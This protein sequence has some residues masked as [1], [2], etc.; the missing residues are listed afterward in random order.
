MPYVDLDGMRLYYAEHGLADG[1]PLVLLHAFMA[2][3]DQ[4]QP[5]LDGFGARYRLIVPDLRGHGRTDNPGGLAAMN[6]RQFAR[7]VAGLC[8]ALDIDRAAFVGV[9]TGA[10]LLLSLALD[11][12]D[13]ARALVLAGGTYH[14]DDELRRWWR[15]MTPESVTSS[16]ERARAVHT[17]LGPDHWRLVAQA[18]IALSEHPHEVDFPRPEELRTIQAPTL[19]VH[20]D[21]DRYF[22]VQVPATLYGLLP[23]AELCIL[24][25]TGHFPQ[26]DRPAWFAD[27]VLDFL[28]RRA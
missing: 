23:D 21:R 19:I 6:H 22:P 15:T 13:L 26:A 3:G 11:A 10:M 20:G 12:P 7:D 14:Y 18:W 17:A 5:H 4:W 16:V 24:P 2:T 9:S 27:I 28:A 8:R 1:S 25:H